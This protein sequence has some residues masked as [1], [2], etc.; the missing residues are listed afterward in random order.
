MHFIHPHACGT[1]SRTPGSRGKPSMQFQVVAIHDRAD[2]TPLAIALLEKTW[3]KSGHA[4]KLQRSRNEWPIHYVAK[5]TDDIGTEKVVAHGCLQTSATPTTTGD[6]Q[7]VLYSLVVDQ[8]FRRHGVG[9]AF[10]GRLELL[11]ASRGCSYMTLSTDDAA[12]FYARCGYRQISETATAAAAVAKVATSGLEALLRRRAAAH[13]GQDA[14]SIGTTWMR[15]RLRCFSPPTGPSCTDVCSAADGTEAHGSLLMQAFDRYRHREGRS[16][17]PDIDWSTIAS[18]CVTWRP[19]I[20]P[21][22]GLTALLCLATTYHSSSHPRMEPEVQATLAATVQNPTARI[23]E[24]AISSGSSYDGE[25]FDAHACAAIASVCL[26]MHVHVYSL[27]AQHVQEVQQRMQATLDTG[28][29]V[30]FPYD[31]DSSAGH[32]PCHAQGWRAH[33][34]WIIGLQ[35]VPTASPGGTT[36]AVLQHTLSPTP[37]IASLAD[38]LSSNG[39]LTDLAGHPGGQAGG[40]V[41]QP[42][43]TPSQWREWAEQRGGRM[44]TDCQ[45]G[46]LAGMCVL[47]QASS[48]RQ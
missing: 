12:P 19:Q 8:D 27:V 1:S 3:P 15:K 35:Q 29:Y 42:A 46:Q 17:G 24:L 7:S 39:Q 10:L 20:G 31:E 48:P 45:Q 33:W 43:R 21:S 41:L 5:S 34:G 22:C 26:G 16:T 38:F 23:F 2:L 47:I 36:C 9:K 30:L 25:L 6:V 11:A 32:S 28:G 40:W 4:F 13:A 37:V 44:T 18:R 14:D